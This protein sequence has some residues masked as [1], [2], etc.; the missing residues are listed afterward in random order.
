MNKT[1]AKTSAKKDEALKM[2]IEALEKTKFPVGDKR[3]DA[4]NACKEALEQPAEPRL[5]SY[6][7]DGSTCTLN[8]DGKEV[9]FNREQPTFDYN[10]AFSHGYE[11]H[12]A[13]R[14]YPAKEEILDKI[15]KATYQQHSAKL[16]QP[17]EGSIT[18]HNLNPEWAMRITADRKIEVNENVEVS[19]AAQKVLDTMQSLLD[20]QQP[21]QEPVE[22]ST[23]GTFPLPKVK[24]ESYQWQGLTSEDINKITD[25][26]NV[27]LIL[28][29]D[30]IDFV[31]A[32]EAKLKE[33]NT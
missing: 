13:E 25:E 19:E 16:M 10:T 32:I 21:A 1:S 31:M 9:Y 2:A 23:S 3:N 28:S 17:N 11:A 33:K 5:V 29:C 26:L 14:E 12:K 20:K 30:I 8:I 24:Y 15:F 6:A 22:I 4:I 7:P 18:F 27:S